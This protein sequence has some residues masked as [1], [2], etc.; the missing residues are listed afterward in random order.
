VRAGQLEAVVG[1]GDELG[2]DGEVR[3]GVRVVELDRAEEPRDAV[4][5]GPRQRLRDDDIGMRPQGHGAQ[6]LQ[7]H[8]IG[9][10]PGEPGHRDP[11]PGHQHGRVRLLPPEPPL[12]EP[13]RATRR[14]GGRPRG[15]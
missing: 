13:P 15:D 12:G 1:I 4:P 5:A 10:H 7:D 14:D 6:D 3:A 8:P 11:H 2:D 9:P